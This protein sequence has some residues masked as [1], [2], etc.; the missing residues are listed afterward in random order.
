MTNENRGRCRAIHL[1]LTL[2]SSRLSAKKLK[3]LL[4]AKR[5]KGL[6][7]KYYPNINFMSRS[8]HLTKLASIFI[9]KVD[10]TKSRSLVY[11]IKCEHE[12]C[13]ASYIGKIERILHHRIKEH[14]ANSSSACH[15]HEKTHQGNR[16]CYGDVE[17]LDSADSNFKLECEELLH[18]VQH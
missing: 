9:I 12:G 15:Q 3:A 13:D 10:T 6:V 5:L 7:N 1:R 11:R 4:S 14:M 8:K 16:L 2:L 18:I 17:I